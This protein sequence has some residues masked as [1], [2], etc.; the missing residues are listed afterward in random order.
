MRTASHM[1]SK[2][3]AYISWTGMKQRCYN[4]KN[5]DYKYYG[6]RGIR[7]CEKWLRSFEAFYQDMG[8]PPPGMTIDRIRN[9]GHYEPGNCRWAT[10][11]EQNTR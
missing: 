4:P 1:M 7:I 11:L 8:E 3:P 5:R 2:S 6:G 9:N 10:R